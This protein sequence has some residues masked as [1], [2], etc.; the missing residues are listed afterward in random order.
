MAF[1][2]DPNSNRISGVGSF[3]NYVPPRENPDD[4]QE[5]TAAQIRQAYSAAIAADQSAQDIIQNQLDGDA[6]IAV[7]PEVKDTVANAKLFVHE[8]DVRFGKGRHP[9]EHFEAAYESLRASGFLA[10]DEKEVAKQQKA[11]AKQHYDVA[12]ALSVTPT[13]EEMYAL[14][15]EELRK[16]DAQERQK[17]F[18]L[19]GERGGNGF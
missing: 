5:L 1:D 2:R 16:L 6:F 13:E 10:L 18:Q 12:K 15:L 4:A 8:M 3:G 7:H 9:I 14:P 11:F 19:S 17:Q